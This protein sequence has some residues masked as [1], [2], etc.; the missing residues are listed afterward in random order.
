MAEN[1]HCFTQSLHGKEVYWEGKRGRGGE[2][3]EKRKREKVT[4]LLRERAE[5]KRVD[6]L[7]CGPKRFCSLKLLLVRLSAKA[8]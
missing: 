4:C 1:K 8:T 6:R 5:R 3:E 2:G 7:Y